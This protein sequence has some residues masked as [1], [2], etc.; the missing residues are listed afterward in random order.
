M[1]VWQLQEPFCNDYTSLSELYFGMKGFILL[2]QTKKVFLW[3]MAAQHKTMEMSDAWPDIFYEGYIH[4]LPPFSP[5]PPPPPPPPPFFPPPPP[6][7]YPPPLKIQNVQKEK[8]QK[9][10]RKLSKKI[11]C[12][13]TSKFYTVFCRFSWKKVKGQYFLAGMVR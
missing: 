1:Q 6:P 4:A 7:H 2:V 9:L 13:L 12:N 8:L 3:A 10:R 5:P 11:F